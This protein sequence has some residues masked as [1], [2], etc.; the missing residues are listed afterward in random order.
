MSARRG[1]LSKDGSTDVEPE[2]F[3]D[4]F[5]KWALTSLTIWPQVHETD[6]EIWVESFRDLPSLPVRVETLTIICHYP[7]LTA[8]TFSAYCW[9]Y[10]N[11]ILP[12]ANLFPAEI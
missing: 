5:S 4:E 10:F 2:A 7:R 3:K 6:T 8:F 9:T 11:H 1:F 12:R